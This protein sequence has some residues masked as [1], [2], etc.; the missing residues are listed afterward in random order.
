MATVQATSPEL[1]FRPAP[2]WR[3]V[4]IFCAL[5]AL[6]AAGTAL[7]LSHWGLAPQRGP[8]DWVA[9]FVALGVLGLVPSLL[10]WPSAVRVDADGIWRRRLVRWDLWPW[11]AF[12]EGRIYEKPGSLSFV[13]PAKP[14]YWR[15]LHLEFL[16]EADRHVLLEVIGRL[17]RRPEPD[18]PDEITISFPFRRRARFTP[19]GVQLW[20]GKQAPGPLL[21]WEDVG[22]VTLHRLYHGR[23]DFQRL[24]FRAPAGGKP[25]RLAFAQERPIWQGAGAEVLA[26]FLERHVP[27]GQLQVNILTGLPRDRTECRRLIALLEQDEACNKRTS[28][29]LL[30]LYLLA[31]AVCFLLF[32]KKVGLNPLQ[33]DVLAW[34]VQVMLLAFLALPFAAAGVIQLYQRRELK[35]RRLGLESWHDAPLSEAGVDS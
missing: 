17:H 30:V 1:H 31:V 19:A 32:P 16:T 2:E 7:G 25:V 21:R 33:W 26:G 12:A 23:R 3:R 20:R 11:D 18:V 4:A 8:A 10:I 5:G 29:Y 34:T 15:E 35:K 22:P 27:P 28:R 14:W 9:V 6:A 24:E 13:F